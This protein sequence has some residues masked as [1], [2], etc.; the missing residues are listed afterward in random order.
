[1]IL[2]EDDDVVAFRDI[3]PKAPF[4]VLIVPKAHIA[5][6]GQLTQDEGPLLGKVFS[7]AASLVAADGYTN[8]YR[9][10]TNVGEDGG[11]SIGH[12]HFHVLAGRPLAWPPG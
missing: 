4:H 2:F 11:Q 6:A 7:L 3:D 10:V 12:L 9:V 1:M 8:G 5:S